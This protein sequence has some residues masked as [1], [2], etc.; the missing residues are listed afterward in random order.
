MRTNIS[1]GLGYRAKS[2]YIDI[3]FI[4]SMQESKELPY[5]L[6]RTNANVQTAT[7][8][9]SVSQLVFTLGRRF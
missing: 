1:G 4:R 3:A 7:I 8:N 9:N 2:W 5:V 6:A